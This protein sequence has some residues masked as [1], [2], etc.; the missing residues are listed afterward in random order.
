MR[1]LIDPT[2]QTLAGGLQQPPILPEAPLILIQTTPVP[3]GPW[4]PNTLLG[5]VVALFLCSCG[6]PQ[7]GAPGQ[8]NGTVFQVSDC[9]DDLHP[10]E[11]AEYAKQCSAAIGE[12]VTK[13]DCDEGTDVPDDHPTG[14]NCDRP[15]V[16]NGV[17]DPGS[18]F[19]VLKQTTDVEIV[20]H[21]RKK[22]NGDHEYGDIAV[23]QY[24]QKNGAT[25]FYQAL[26]KLPAKMPSPLNGTGGIWQDPQTTAGQKC[27]GC[28]DNGPFIR[29]PYL[30]QL[31][32]EVTNRLPGTKLDPGRWDNR[33]GWN[34]TLPYAFV[35]NDFQSWKVYSLS[36]TGTG[37]DCMGCHRLALSS[38]RVGGDP[39]VFFDGAGGG[40]MQ[41][42]AELYGPIATAATQVS[43]NP[44]SADSPIWMKPGQNTYNATVENQAIAAA[45]CAKALAVFGNNPNALPPPP[46]CNSVQYGQGTS[47]RGGAIRA[48]LNGAT[49]ST[50]TTGRVDTVV[51]LGA[52]ASGDCPIGFC[53]WRSVHG[54]FWQT[55]KSTIP[56]DDA[57][58]RGS[59]VR[60]YGEGGAW[61]SRAMMDNTGGL[62]NAPP[63]GAVEC[64][65]FDEIAA[66]PDPKI[67]GSGFTTISDPDGS[68]ASSSA[69]TK[70]IKSFNVLSG[71]IGNVAQLSPDTPDFL[72][73]FETGGKVLLAQQHNLKP[74]TSIKLGPFTG[75]SWTN[76]CGSWSPVYAAKEVFSNSDV[77]LVAYPKSKDVRC[78]IT[79]VTGAWSNTRNSATVQPFA[80]I[81]SGGAKDLRLRVFPGTNNHDSVG[82]Y[83]SCIV[84]K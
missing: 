79:G 43:K 56:I 66:V 65:R 53:Y 23:I 48:V 84:L 29:S 26:G 12:D 31:R 81:Y 5:V 76:G 68:H 35:G 44:H 71:L 32:T 62:A 51:N 74:P 9:D 7:G 24:N 55:S 78:F 39:V 2:G 20:A 37:S 47:C 19:Q 64:S 36:V 73:V 46:G 54:P 4:L 67:C 80:E 82:A 18:K 52:C 33:F 83:A 14:G 77:Q 22:G 11:L 45:A 63:G 17:C 42:T 25:C 57:A 50:P 13:F 60:I 10:Q 70:G 41:G 61:K 28:H 40:G 30:A 72:K 58:F 27:I 34:Q 21:C 49:Q 16:L 59:L 15:N 75:E 69:D 3:R 38:R 8:P 6:G 1:T